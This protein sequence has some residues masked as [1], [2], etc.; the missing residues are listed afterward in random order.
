MFIK[1]TFVHT[2]YFWLKNPSDIETFVE[3]V[4]SLAAN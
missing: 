1:D 2:V 4:K 3:G